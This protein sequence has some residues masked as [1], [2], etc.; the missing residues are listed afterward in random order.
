MDRKLRPRNTEVE[1][2][3]K[4]LPLLK[5]L[6]MSYILTGI[7]LLL[8]AFLL[9][10]FG[11]SE[12]IVSIAIIVIYLAATVL[13]GF[14]AGRKM[15]NRRFLWGLAE[16][17]AYFLVLAVISLIVNRSVSAL[18]DS[19]FTTLLLCAGGGMMGGMIG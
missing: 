19:F 7:L 14:C 6:L 13:A 4:Y 16:G 12:K 1:G 5:Y 8:L 10:R 15:G 17:C 11:L 9:Y 3:A 2:A 18:T